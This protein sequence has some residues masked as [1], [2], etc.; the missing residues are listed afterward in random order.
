M[1]VRHQRPKQEI[2]LEMTSMIDVV[3]Q[4]LTFFIMTFK[5]VSQEGD[6]NIKM[7]LAAPSQGAIDEQLIPP[8]KVRLQAGSGGELVAIAMNQRAVSNMQQLHEEIISLVGSDSPGGAEGAEVEFDCD[9]NL[10]YEHVIEAITAVSG[11]RDRATGEVVKLIE[12]VKFAPPRS[13][14]S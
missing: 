12:K 13:P 5:I 1:K 10:R 11:Y 7:P 9:Y 4:L 8:I 6:F 2:K 3:F 14:P